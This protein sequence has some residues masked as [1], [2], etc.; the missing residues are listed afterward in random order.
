MPDDLGHSFAVRFFIHPSFGTLV[1]SFG[2]SFSVS[3]NQSVF[4]FSV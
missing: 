1:F 3:S 2:T 4:F